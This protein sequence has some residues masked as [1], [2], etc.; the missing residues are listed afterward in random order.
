MRELRR[1]GQSIP[2]LPVVSALNER[3]IN[4]F[5]SSAPDLSAFPPDRNFMYS[6]AVRRQ[7][8]ARWPHSIY[9]WA[10]AEAMAQ[11]GFYHQPTTADDDRAMCFTCNVCLVC[12]EPTDEPW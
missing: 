4:L 11:A 6:E 3:L 5:P 8:F 10:G 9:K 2:A 7:T 12:W 1:L